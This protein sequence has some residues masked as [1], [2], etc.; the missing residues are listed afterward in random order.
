MSMFGAVRSGSFNVKRIL[1]RRD[2]ENSFY[3]GKPFPLPPNL[4]FN[5]DNTPFFK[6]NFPF[7]SNS[8]GE[9]K[10]V[11]LNTGDKEII[12]GQA[13]RVMNNIFDFPYRNNVYLGEKIQWDCDYLSGYQWSSEISWKGNF[14]TLPKGTDIVNAWLQGRLNQLIY[15][16]KAYIITEDE[17]YVLHYIKLLND[18]NSSNRFCTGVNWLNPAEVSVRLLNIVFSLSMIIHSDSISETHLN[19]FLRIILLHSIFIEN[20]LNRDSSCYEYLVGIS[21]LA[22]SGIVL[23]DIDYGKKLIQLSYSRIEEAIRKVI[24]PEGISNIRSVSYHPHIIEAFIITK[25]SLEKAGLKLSGFFLERYSRMFDVLA[26]LIRQDGSVALIGETFIR[27]ILPFSENKNSFPLAA[28]CIEQ[29]NG[30]YKSFISSSEDLLFLKGGEAVNKFN[31]ITPAEYPH[32]SYGYVKSGIF[33]LRNDDIHITIDAAENSS[34]TKQTEGHNDILS[35]ELFYKGNPVIIDS[36]TYSLFADADIR[37]QQRSVKSH[38]TLLIDDEEPAVLEGISGI[39][40]DL[41][42]PKIT[43][44]R[45]D[46]KSDLLSVQH[47]AYA[48]F[49]DPVVVKRI[50]RLRKELNIIRIRDELF[51][52]SSHKCTMN[53]LLHPHIKIQQTGRHS[54]NFG[55]GE[56]NIS[57]P[58]DIISASLQDSFCSSEYGKIIST[59]KLVVNISTRLPVYFETEIKLL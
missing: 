5:K 13:D 9:I 11:L 14:F 57:A 41:T 40:E 50:F 7:S 20:N 56:I 49:A 23:K 15:L 30:R 38:N 25:A 16:G 35:F 39:K 4:T 1:F 24:N 33:I 46:E 21:S 43:E 58:G 55:S 45:S 53:Y 17:K 12:I 26:S 36:G 10:D 27:R 48:R 52:G 51:G 32:I 18:F 2:V 6:Q 31:E 34:G 59:K 44:W 37:N 22:V 19:E 54:F 3:S 29:Y 28:G 42:R 8:A 47:Y